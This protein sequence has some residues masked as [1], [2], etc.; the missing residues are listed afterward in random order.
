MLHLGHAE[1]VRR[2]QRVRA[3]EKPYDV[4]RDLPIN[5][6]RRNRGGRSAAARAV[7]GIATERERLASYEMSTSSRDAVAFKVAGRSR[8]SASMSSLLPVRSISSCRFSTT[9]RSS[10]SSCA[11]SRTSRAARRRSQMV[12]ASAGWP[13]RP[14]RYSSLS[15]GGSAGPTDGRQVSAASHRGAAGTEPSHRTAPPCRRCRPAWLGPLQDGGHRRHARGPSTPIGDAR[16]SKVYGDTVVL[17][18]AANGSGRRMAVL[19]SGSPNCR[20]WRRGR[21]QGGW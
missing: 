3:V 18:G 12:T 15:S 10:P 19:V 14:H 6:G 20:F 1:P 2:Q 21:R 9:A 11:A 13:R 8:I 7:S 4:R 5:A 16:A 17:V